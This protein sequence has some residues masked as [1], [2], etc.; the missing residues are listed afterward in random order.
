MTEAL[1]ARA[2]TDVETVVLAARIQGVTGWVRPS[3]ELH[4]EGEPGELRALVPLLGAIEPARVEGHEQFALRGVSTGVFT[5]HEHQATTH[6]YDFRL[7]VGEVMR[8]WAVPRGPSL[9]PAVQRLAVEV[10]DHS[11]SLNR[12]EGRGGA[13]KAVIVWDCGTYEQDGRVAF[14]EALARGHAA[15]VLHGTKLRGGFVL[16]R[17]R[18]GARPLWLLAKRADG[19]ARPGSNVVAE[20]PAS[21]LSG[22]T[23][24]ELLA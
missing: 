7:Q 14:P 11:P 12:I 22:R 2:A 13:G 20:R 24:A 4:A 9:D 23:L 16:Q 6:H 5:V 19:D 17:T 8:S 18:G 15:F 3:G 1:R 21:P 10:D